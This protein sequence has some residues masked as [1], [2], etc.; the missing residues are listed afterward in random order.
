M[1]CEHCHNHVRP[2]VA[3]DIDGTSANW[4]ASF[5]QFLESYLGVSEESWWDYNG[6]GELSEWLM[7]DKRTY[8]EAKLAFRSGGFKRWME[9]REGLGGFVDTC[10]RLGCDL[11]I[12]T[13]RPWLRLDNMDPD[14]REWLRRNEVP[15][16]GLLYDD[17]K[18]EQLCEAV[19]RDRVVLVLEDQ[20]DQYQSA[21]AVGLP[22]ALMGSNWNRYYWAGKT[23]VQG[24]GAANAMLERNMILWRDKHG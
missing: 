6:Q 17:A 23:V 16:K 24:F 7:L 18:Y 15:Y 9:P 10:N 11:W 12:T 22:V 13:T 8:Q 21:R 14:T 5:L 3:L 20:S 2:V 4:H 1:K 19:D